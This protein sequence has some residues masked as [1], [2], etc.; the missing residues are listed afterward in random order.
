MRL[1]VALGVITMQ[2]PAISRQSTNLGVGHLGCFLV[3]C[4]K[5]GFGAGLPYKTSKAFAKDK[6]QKTP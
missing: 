2:K 5:A 6:R 3:V 1:I 4:E